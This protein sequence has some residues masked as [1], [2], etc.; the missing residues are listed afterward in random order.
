MKRIKEILNAL[1]VLRRVPSRAI[2]SALEAVIDDAE[3]GASDGGSSTDFDRTLIHD[4]VEALIQISE[5][6]EAKGDATKP[7][8]VAT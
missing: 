5:A 1:R 7:T 4:L 3:R 2:K 8:E 6:E